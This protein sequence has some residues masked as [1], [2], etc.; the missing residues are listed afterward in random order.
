MRDP[1]ATDP[2]PLL[3]LLRL[4]NAPVGA[5]AYSQGLE[6]AVEAGL[7]SNADQ[8]RGWTMGLLHHVQARQDAPLFARL[9]RAWAAE[10]TRQAVE[11]NARLMARRDTAELRAE[12][13][14]TG[15]A[16][17]RLLAGLGVARADQPA[18]HDFGHGAM[19]ALACVEWRVPL[20]E[21]ACGYL[22]SWCQNQVAAAVKLVP[23]GQTAGQRLLGELS[24]RIPEAVSCAL[25]LGD[26]DIGCAAPGLA[27][28][29]ARHERQ[30]TRLFLS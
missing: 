6:Q 5:F 23:L 17:A 8:A 27:L 25:A 1:A 18:E 12:E 4:A 2:T 24:E 19:F 14:A 16:L 22:W 20:A 3:S 26:D 11:W 28:A 7:V 10:S 29:S 30:Y 9:Y 15:A 21:A 13:R